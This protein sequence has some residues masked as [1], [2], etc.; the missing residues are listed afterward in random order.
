MG[1]GKGGGG[2]QR[3][4]AESPVESRGP[5][6][7]SLL[8]GVCKLVGRYSELAADFDVA[9]GELSKASSAIT[10]LREQ[11]GE[12]VK[13]AQ[14][15]AKKERAALVQTA[16]SSLDHLRFHLVSTLTGLRDASRPNLAAKPKESI[17]W[18]PTQRRDARWGT[19]HMDGE[20]DHLVLR[21]EMPAYQPKL[22][23]FA[24][25]VQSIARPPHRSPRGR[26]GEL[27]GSEPIWQSSAL[28]KPPGRASRLPV[29]LASRGGPL[30]SLAN[31]AAILMHQ[32]E[33]RGTHSRALPLEPIPDGLA[34]GMGL[35]RFPRA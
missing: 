17:T 33:L 31:Q 21:L 14:D 16:L 32:K 9:M 28:P 7:S 4:L 27:A 10:A 11:T 13:E 3:R 6:P 24:A 20:G 29:S 15:T 30:P 2:G 25:N 34:M 12:K 22:A 26:G 8:A 35:G 1:A 19:A 18:Q 5:A 23:A